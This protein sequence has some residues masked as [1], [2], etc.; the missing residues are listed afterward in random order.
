MLTYSSQSTPTTA[1]A[2][3]AN[4]ATRGH[5]DLSPRAT[6]AANSVSTS[7]S[8][9]TATSLPARRCGDNP[10][11]P[12]AGRQC[13]RRGGVSTGAVDANSCLQS[14]HGILSGGGGMEA[15]ATPG[16][17]RTTP[18]GAPRPTARSS[19]RFV[20][21][22]ARLQRPIVAA[23][24]RFRL[25][26]RPCGI[27]R[28]PRPHPRRTPASGRTGSRQPGMSRLLGEVEGQ[29]DAQHEQRQQRR[30]PSAEPD[31]DRGDRQ[32]SH[33]RDD[34]QRGQVVLDDAQTLDGA[35]FDRGRDDRSLAGGRT[36]AAVVTA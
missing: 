15:S 32:A 3:T 33:G 31:T 6:A 35:A 26:S 20:P 36:G 19:H 7:H 5:Q 25:P 17:S 9:S 21:T 14:A 12:I 8:T 34:H 24:R 11:P 10:W 1:P 27:R 4:E 30:D 16:R 13:R 22:P 18:G 29:A 23:R 2:T 28:T